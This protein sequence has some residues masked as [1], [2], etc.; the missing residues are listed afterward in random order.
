MELQSMLGLISMASNYPWLML[1]VSA[2]FVF[3]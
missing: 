2:A 1:C 3:S